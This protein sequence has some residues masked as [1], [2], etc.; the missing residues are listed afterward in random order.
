MEHKNICIIGAGIS[1]ISVCKF[2]KEKGITDFQCYEL[3]DTIGGNWAFKNKNGMSSAYRSLHID[4]SKEKL[5]FDDYPMPAD[6][7]AFCH[8]TQIYAYF[9]EV[10]KHFG[11]MQYIRLNTGVEK[12]ERTEEGLWK[13][14]LSTGESFLYKYLIVCNG[15]HWSPSWPEFEGNFSGQVI[16]SHEYIDPFDPI[17]M[18]GKRVLVVGFGN[19]A[20]DIACELSNKSLA[21]QLTVSTR[22]G[23]WVVPKYVFGK[24]IDQAVQTMKHVPLK[25]Q[26]KAAGLFLK[27]LVGNMETYGLPKPDHNVLEAHPTVSSEFL[28]KAG[29]GD[30]KVKPNIKRLEG[31]TVHFSDGT[32]GEFDV[33]IYATGYKITFPFF[34]HSL[35][36]TEHNRL[37]LFKRVFLPEYN[38]LMFI[39]F[40]QAVPSLIKFIQDQA[41]FVATYLAGQYQLPSKEEM[42]RIIEKDEQKHLAHFV[43][44]DRHTMQIDHNTYRWDIEKEMKRR[45]TKSSREN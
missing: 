9:Q 10:V 34:D 38:N 14:R 15:H 26:R 16:H 12:V 25:W 41:R 8:H 23:A 4:T 35:L 17:D 40:A 3:S 39:G 20:V 37:R 32:S 27:L 5:Q 24:P 45:R 44:T 1:G 11:L 33:I 30:I 36:N 19:S 13:I 42:V 2:L 31:N 28:Y 7:P 22:R 18:R 6:Y 43:K 29:T 21:K